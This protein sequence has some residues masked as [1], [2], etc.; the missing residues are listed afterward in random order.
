MKGSGAGG[1]PGAPWVQ[2]AWSMARGPHSSWEDPRWGSELR[3][4]AHSSPN[5]SLPVNLSVVG[6][7]GGGFLGSGPLCWVHQMLTQ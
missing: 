1:A 7:I 3:V 2:G 6:G 5:Y 4:A